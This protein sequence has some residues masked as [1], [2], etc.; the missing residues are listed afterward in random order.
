MKRTGKK[1]FWR[2][3]HKWLGLFFAI[4]LLLFCLSGIVLNHRKFF[5]GV[6]ISRSWL[7]KAY[8]VKNWNQ[9]SVKGTLRL[10]DGRILAYGQAGIWETGQSMEYRRDFSEGLKKGVDNRKISSLVQAGDGSLW[11]TGLYDLYRFSQETGRWK[12]V[13]LKGNRERL[14]DM[15]LKGRDTVVVLSRSS[16]Y[17]AVAPD[18][19]FNEITLS[20]P[21]GYDNKVTLF[22]TFW[23]IHSGELFGL[24]GKLVVDAVALALILLSITGIVFFVLSQSIRR[25]KVKGMAPER[26][27]SKGQRM[28]RH[29]G[30]HNKVGVWTLVF[31]LILSVTGMCLRPPLMIPLVRAK[32]SPVPGSTLASKNVFHDKLRSMRWDESRRCWLLSTSEGFYIIGDE[33]DRTA[34][35]ALKKAPSVSPMGIHVFTPDPAAPSRWLIGSFSGLFSWNPDDG[36]VTDWFTGEA[37]QRGPYGAPATHAVTGW[38]EDIAPSPVVF[39]YYAGPNIQL[40]SMPAPISSLRMSLWNFALELHVG[41]CYE[42]FLGSVLSVLFVFLSGAILTLVLTS[43]YIIYKKSVNHS[44][45]SKS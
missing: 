22:K 21:D 44:K 45:K 35:Q 9:G 33:L 26:I 34:P 38:S 40:A 42:P 15:T 18:Y 2:A 10:S 13:E 19:T 16:V 27:K 37:P 28:K 39:D 4:F 14:S 1:T 8:K 31:T 20:V 32:V 23:M 17:Q 41:R 25:G 5:S 3:S 7:P 43:G 36:S 6:S 12:S 30:W 11:C 29:L 24:V